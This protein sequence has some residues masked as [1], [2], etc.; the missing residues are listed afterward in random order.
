MV[1]RDPLIRDTCEWLFSIAL[2]VGLVLSAAVVVV[3]LWAVVVLVG[4]IP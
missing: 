3:I 1:N 2:G 4:K